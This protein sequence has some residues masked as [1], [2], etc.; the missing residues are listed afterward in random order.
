MSVTVAIA[1][2][3]PGKVRE[4]RAIFLDTSFDL[5]DAS[6]FG[7]WS[8]PSEDSELYVENALAKA[9][10]L[11]AV[12]DLPV[13]ADDSGIEADAL[14][15]APGVRSARYAGPGASD[16]ENVQALLRALDG[17]SLERRTGRFRCVAVCATPDGRS[18]IEEATVEGHIIDTPRGSNGFGYDPIFVPLGE[19]RTTAEMNPLEKEAI[20]HRG[21]A[22]RQLIPEMRRLL[23]HV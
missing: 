6:A 13:V 23:E 7:L 21:K 22:F 12:S 11:A 2:T 18:V 14:G 16:S 15:G 17:V 20:S 4:I 9:R 19:T 8:P 1:S 3:N 5:V 10:T